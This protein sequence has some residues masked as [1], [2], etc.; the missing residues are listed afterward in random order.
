MKIFRFK[1]CIFLLG[2]NASENTSIV[3]NANEN[4]IWFHLDNY[5]S[6]HGLLLNNNEK[7]PHQDD[8]HECA[9]ILVENSKY[10]NLKKVNVIYSKAKYITPDK[11]TR[12]KV[13]LHKR[14]RYF[15]KIKKSF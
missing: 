15:E 13:Y 4:D 11:Y 9:K 1:N 6:A 7:L 8:I 5:S 2:Q 12:G 3:K 10:R 14:H